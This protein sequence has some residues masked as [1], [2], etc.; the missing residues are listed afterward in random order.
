MET[1]DYPPNALLMTPFHK[2]SL[3]Q[4]YTLRKNLKTTTPGWDQS[5]EDFITITTSKTTPNPTTPS[6]TSTSTPTDSIV[7]EPEPEPQ[8]IVESTSKKFVVLT[9]YAAPPPSSSNK[10]TQPPPPPQI[11]T[12]LPPPPSTTLPWYKTAP[13][14]FDPHQVGPIVTDLVVANINNGLIPNFLWNQAIDFAKGDGPR[15]TGILLEC[16]FLPPCPT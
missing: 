5:L 3:K 4:K 14:I 11:T 13:N 9:L 15:V 1:S 6:P 7:Y 2:K 8:P 16:I 12:P 10:A